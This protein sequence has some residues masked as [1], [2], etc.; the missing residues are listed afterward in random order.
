VNGT[1]LVPYTVTAAASANVSQYY[2]TAGHGVYQPGTPFTGRTNTGWA[3]TFTPTVGVWTNGGSSLGGPDDVVATSPTNNNFDGR[4]R[5]SFPPYIGTITSANLTVRSRAAGSWGAATGTTNTSLIRYPISDLQT[6]SWAEGVAGAD[7]DTARWNEV[8]D[9]WNTP[10]DAATYINGTNTTEYRAG[11]TAPSIPAGATNI[12]VDLVWRGRDGTSNT[13]TVFS[14]L[15]YD[16]TW[17]SAATKNPTT[18]WTTYTDTWAT[19]PGGAAWTPA[20]VALITGLGVDASGTGPNWVTQMYVRVNYT[21]TTYNDDTW[22]IQYTTNGSTWNNLAAP[23]A[24]AE[25]ALTN[26]TYNLSDILTAANRANFAVR[27]LGSVVGSADNVGTIQWDSSTLDITYSGTDPGPVRADCM[28]CHEQHGSTLRQLLTTTVDGQSVPHYS[29]TD[30]QAQCLACHRSGGAAGTKDIARYYPTGAHGTATQSVALPGTAGATLFGHR[31]KTAG[32]LPAGSALPCRLCHNPHGSAGSGY[33]LAVRTNINGTAHVIGDASGELL[34]SAA[35]QTAT[36]VRRFCLACHVT[37]DGMGTDAAGTGSTAITSGTILGIS[38]TSGA[39]RLPA[40]KKGHADADTESCYVCHGDD[41]TQSTSV[42]VHNPSSGESLGGIAC[43]KCH[44]VYREQMEDRDGTELGGLTAR[45]EGYHHVLGN[46]ATDGDSAFTATVGQPATNTYPTTVAAGAQPVYCLSCHVDHDKFSPLKNS[47]F[48]RSN[49]LRTNYSVASPTATNTDFKQ[50]A[51]YDGSSSV[52][53]GC[54]ATALTKDNLN[55]K[56]EPNSSTTP[57]ITAAQYGASAHNYY[58]TSTFNDGVGATP[59]STF[60]ANCSKCHDS[61]TDGGGMEAASATRVGFQTSTNKF[62]VHVSANRRILAAMGVEIA[63]PA[64]EEDVCYKC[65]S[66]GYTTG[67]DYYAVSSMSAASRSVQSLMDSTYKH[68]VA[69]YVD[70]HK[71]SPADE[72]LTYISANRH[73]ECADCHNVH[74]AGSGIHA[75]GTNVVSGPL[76]GVPGASVSTA[77]GTNWDTATYNNQANYAMVTGSTYEYQICLKCHSG[78]N[79]SLTSWNSLFT[80]VA[81][82]FNTSNASYHPVFGALPATDAGVGSSRLPTGRLVNG[83]TS[84]TVMMCSDCHGPASTT[85]AAQG[86]HGSTVQFMLKGPRTSWPYNGTTEI[87]LANAD[88]NNL[89]CMNCHPDPET[90]NNVHTAHRGR[91]SSSHCGDCHIRVPH[92]GKM[93]RLMT[94]WDSTTIP[95]RYRFG[96]S[97]NGLTRFTKQTG[98]YGQNNSCAAAGCYDGHTSG[99][100]NW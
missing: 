46:G 75:Q 41:F 25:A 78:A 45:L 77:S 9:V 22:A 39:L 65:H 47:A 85:A 73:V 60:N 24:T 76:K 55:Q 18:T 36:N 81:L 57:A 83:W 93:S 71:P 34:M 1:T 70:G 63:D 48:D 59:T 28:D 72:S 10:D 12:T 92:G 91:T 15:L 97:S 67:S 87:T 100:E 89:F 16:G 32:T 4:H 13:N 95:S 14:R 27:I 66:G 19:A 21:I 33:M 49:N 69:G 44:S 68:N 84:G 38:R 26:H 52:C 29:D 56:S 88:T 42:N 17:S 90:T 5:F 7:G 98:S 20:N 3:T 6:G 40:G 43:Y 23:S 74:A 58:A 37:S 31:T 54:H 8:D 94:D 62:S 64:A 99:T 50:A 51:P 53:L 11:I 30:D 82:E 79:T 61:E 35:Q 96:S 80:N 86:P 2:S